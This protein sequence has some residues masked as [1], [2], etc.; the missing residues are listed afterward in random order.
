MPSLSIFSG[1]EAPSDPVPLATAWTDQPNLV[2]V[3]L[4]FKRDVK[5]TL[6]PALVADVKFSTHLFFDQII[7]NDNLLRF[8]PKTGMGKS[9]RRVDPSFGPVNLKKGATIVKEA[10]SRG[11]SDKACQAVAREW[12]SPGPYQP[13]KGGPFCIGENTLKHQG[14]S[15]NRGSAP[16]ERLVHTNPPP[17]SRII[18]NLL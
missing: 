10:G 18:P 13:T 3:P 15:R 4:T 9:I 2:A 16:H 14:I 7:H 17:S 6:I 5:T 12:A 11:R 8:I 1:D